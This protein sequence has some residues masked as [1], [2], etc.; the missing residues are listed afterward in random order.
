MNKTL[1]DLISLIGPLQLLRWDKNKL[2][3]KIMHEYFHYCVESLKK[4]KSKK[5]VSSLW[6][7]IS[8]A[9]SLHPSLISSEYQSFFDLLSVTDITVPSVTNMTVKDEFIWSCY[10]MGEKISNKTDFFVTDMNVQDETWASIVREFSKLKDVSLLV[11]LVVNWIQISSPCLIGIIGMPALFAT[12]ILASNCMPAEL[13]KLLN[14]FL[15]GLQNLNQR[16]IHN[17]NL[18]VLECWFA[19]LLNGCVVY[20]GFIGSLNET[21]IIL[22]DYCINRPSVSVC[23]CHSSSILSVSHQL[24]SVAT[25]SVTQRLREWD[26]PAYL[27]PNISVSDIY[28][29]SVSLILKLSRDIIREEN[30][31]VPSLM[32]FDHLIRILGNL[33]SMASVTNDVTD[34]E[35]KNIS[36]NKLIK[37]LT[38]MKAHET[39]SIEDMANIRY[40][41]ILKVLNC[42]PHI[43]SFDKEYLT[44]YWF[45]ISSNLTILL[46]PDCSSPYL[47]SKIYCTLS[48]DHLS[49]ICQYLTVSWKLMSDEKNYEI[50]KRISK[51]D[52]LNKDS[53]YNEFPILGEPIIRQFHEY[54]SWCNERLQ[55]KLTK[56]N[57]KIKNQ[58]KA[59]SKI[60]R[61]IYN[62]KD[63][64]KEF[65]KIPKKWITDVPL[66]ILL[67]I[68]GE[69]TLLTNRAL[70]YFYNKIDLFD[71]DVEVLETCLFCKIKLIDSHEK[72][73]QIDEKSP[74][75]I[76]SLVMSTDVL[77]EEFSS[78]SKKLNKSIIRWL[79]ENDYMNN[80]TTNEQLEVS[81][82][83]LVSQTNFQKLPK[84]TVS[85]LINLDSQ[86]MLQWMEVLSLFETAVRSSNCCI[87][88]IIINIFD[89]KK[90]LERVTDDNCSCISEISYITCMLKRPSWKFPK[91]W[92]FLCDE[93]KLFDFGSFN[94][95]AVSL[96]E[97]VKNSIS[98]Q[99]IEKISLYFLIFTMAVTASNSEIMAVTASNSETMAV[100]ATGM[101]TQFSNTITDLTNAL[102]DNFK[103]DDVEIEKATSLV[104]FGVALLLKLSNTAT[105]DIIQIYT[106]LIMLSLKIL[107]KDIKSLVEDSSQRFI[108]SSYRM[109]EGSQAVIFD[110]PLI[111]QLY[112]LSK[113][114]M[115]FRVNN[116]SFTRTSDS[117]SCSNLYQI[118]R[119]DTYASEVASIL[120]ILCSI[121]NF[122]PKRSNFEQ[123][124]V[125]Q[126]FCDQIEYFIGYANQCLIDA[127]QSAVTEINVL[128]MIASVQMV[129]NCSNFCKNIIKSQKDDKNRFNLLKYCTLTLLDM[130]QTL[131]FKCLQMKDAFSSNNSP[132]GNPGN[133]PP[134]GNSRP[135]GKSR[136]PGNSL[137]PGNNKNA[138]S[139]EYDK[140]ISRG[141]DLIEP[142]GS[143]VAELSHVCLYSVLQQH[144]ALDSVWLPRLHQILLISKTLIYAIPNF[145][146]VNHSHRVA[147]NLTRIWSL[148]IT[149]D[150]VRGTRRQLSAIIAD[151]LVIRNQLTV[152]E[153]ASD[154]WAAV[155]RILLY[156]CFSLLE[157]SDEHAKQSIFASL[158]ESL[159]ESF[160][161]I[162]RMHQDN[163]KFSGKV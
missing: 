23:N 158:D 51:I 112:N 133:N 54:F 6:E 69:L 55:V 77:L 31:S 83:R 84:K 70:V 121:F 48:S 57:N 62:I 74:Y 53:I 32:I 72:T 139:L 140:K 96:I 147:S 88:K 111:R 11:N 94:K 27:N 10:C 9:V 3:Q 73:A 150:R 4:I 49:L 76:L 144:N 65:I 5:S 36:S 113:L 123:D 58:C 13:D 29:K 59:E 44:Y 89:L 131:S 149:D 117:C 87:S 159:K 115:N 8:L 25:I 160:K 153:A 107:K 148:L 98:D 119:S 154:N 12:Q 63:L 47:T 19:F 50:L 35:L 82:R 78:S 67:L 122:N 21:L 116:K 128:I 33:I 42:L 132:P 43:D 92:Q 40:S 71:I 157:I 101:M 106:N 97:S 56:F 60:E 16:S 61:I 142:L 64:L 68:T 151:V 120:I 66:D 126:I 100:A 143:V 110:L 99:L 34:C 46:S 136:P 146:D 30:L 85:Q 93:F 75:Y 28:N 102:L 130:S 45:F 7:G 135:P 80:K 15:T 152:L 105:D 162:I 17:C 86:L 134:P 103:T 81:L 145:K 26:K 125:T 95:T 90:L 104:E 138:T 38:K 20:E 156:G 22:C 41:I 155:G 2:I 114:P 118:I 52:F 124:S 109:I 127:D 141:V 39:V 18:A 108:L 91:L 161:K 163:Y 14:T 79:D 129:S 37:L 24:L 137:P 1:V